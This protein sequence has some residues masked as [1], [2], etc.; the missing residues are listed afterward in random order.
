MKD[1]I[2]RAESYCKAGADAILIHSKSK[3]SDEVIKFA[4]IFTKKKY[5]KTLVCVPSTYSKTYE[6]KLIKSGFKIIIY[7]NHQIRASYKAMY[8]TAESILKNKR[9]HETE[10]NIAKIEEVLTLIE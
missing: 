1:A 9:S 4:Q 2:K 3:T 5:A 8:K 10:K 7:A 6:K